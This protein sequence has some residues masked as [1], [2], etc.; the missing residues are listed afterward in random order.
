MREARKLD[1]QHSLDRA[2]A[3]LEKAQPI[4]CWSALITLRARIDRARSEVDSLV[5]DGDKILDRAK[6]S[7]DLKLAPQLY[8][9]AIA[10]YTQAPTTQP[11]RP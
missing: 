7:L 11:R 1:E 10:K 3:T 9:D 4:P 8:L 2:Q 6:S 5:H